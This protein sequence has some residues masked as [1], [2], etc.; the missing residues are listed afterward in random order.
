MPKVVAS[1]NTAHIS[2]WVANFLHYSRS[3][4]E[5]T[6]AWVAP[7]GA[8]S[9]SQYTLEQ[10]SR[11]QEFHQMMVDR[12]ITHLRPEDV[13]DGFPDFAWKFNSITACRAKFI[14][15]DQ[16]SGN[17]WF[18]QSPVTFR[19]MDLHTTMQPSKAAKVSPRDQTKK[20]T[21]SKKAEKAVSLTKAETAEVLELC[22]RHDRAFE[23][24]LKKEE[25]KLKKDK[26]NEH[27]AKKRQLPRQMFRNRSFR[28]Q[29]SGPFSKSQPHPFGESPSTMSQYT[30]QTPPCSSVPTSKPNQVP[31]ETIDPCLFPAL[32]G[33]TLSPAQPALPTT[34][35]ATNQAPVALA[36]AG[37]AVAANAR[38]AAGANPPQG[39][40]QDVVMTAPGQSTLPGTTPKTSLPGSTTTFTQAGPTLPPTNTV[41]SI[42]GR[43]GTSGRDPVFPPMPPQALPMDL[44]PWETLPELPDSSPS[45][46]IFLPSAPTLPEIPGDLEQ[47]LMSMVG[48]MTTSTSWGLP[49]VVM[50]ASR[51]P[52][53]PLGYTIPNIIQPPAPDS[54]DLGLFLQVAEGDEDAEGELDGSLFSGDDDVAMEH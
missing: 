32:A 42:G 20:A 30:P 35:P 47:T 22:R 7:G 52:Q 10:I 16:T 3:R 24:L 18:P 4:Q 21:S 45:T 8:V 27:F 48:A 34:A 46:P 15:W 1:L 54:V 40:D 5:F 11:F 19:D 33:M 29:P 6:L 17:V 9:S 53:V 13:P 31:Q 37:A 49:S 36:S 51:G 12:R 26:R 44:P 2:P 41:S 28:P 25:E 38:G 39:P 23:V 43:N 50:M 14:L